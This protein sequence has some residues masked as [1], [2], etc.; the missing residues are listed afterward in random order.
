V[1][2]SSSTIERVRLAAGRGRIA[3]AARRF[4]RD[5]RVLIENVLRE[6]DA[7]R[8]HAAAASWTR[9]NLVTRIDSAHRDFNPAGLAALPQDKAAVVQ[10]LIDREARQGFQYLF[11][12]YALYDAARAGRLDDPDLGAAFAFVRSPEFLELA[13]TITGRSEIAYAD[14]QLTRFRAGHYLARHDDAVDGKNRVAAYVINLTRGWR[15]DCGGQLQFLDGDGHVE[16]A[17][18]PTFNA[19]AMFEVP[20][21]HAVSPVAPWVDGHRLSITGWLRSGRE[22]GV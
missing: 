12:T 22:A 6:E 14:A 17:Y 13:R 16:R 3:D 5:R 11:E 15:A 2:D 18:T 9:W 8:L 20:T 21:P 19:L 4:A 1:N 7:A 10:G